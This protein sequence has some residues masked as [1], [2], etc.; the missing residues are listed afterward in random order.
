MPL[1]SMK[2]V[3]TRL[4]SFAL[5]GAIGFVVDAS[6]LIVMINGFGWGP[7]AARFVSFGTAV[8]MTWYLNR[9]WTFSSQAGHKKRSE[10]VRYVAFQSMGAL[11]NLAIYSLCLE[12]IALVAAYPVL[13]VAAGSAVALFFNFYA[14]KRFVYLREGITF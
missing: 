1:L 10:Y 13:G 6:V 11:L 7:Y 12:T 4:V 8:T 9:R 2:K 5:V 3:P 14:S